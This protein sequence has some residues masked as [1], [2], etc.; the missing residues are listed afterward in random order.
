VKTGIKLPHVMN[1]KC[2]KAET[3]MKNK[4]LTENSLLSTFIYDV[5]LL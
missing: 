4:N 1:E 2:A 3:Q 5:K